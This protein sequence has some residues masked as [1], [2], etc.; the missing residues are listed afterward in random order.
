[1]CCCALES[2]GGASRT[3]RRG[4]RNGELRDCE[5][6]CGPG[7]RPHSAPLHAATA[8]TSIFLP[9]CRL[10]DLAWD[11]MGCR[12]NWIWGSPRALS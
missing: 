12:R 3:R 10:A 6:A 4:W 1:V 5:E 7:Q 2:F 8:P 9:P 11:G